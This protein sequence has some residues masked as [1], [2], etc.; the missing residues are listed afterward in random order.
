V[1]FKNTRAISYIDILHNKK[2][3]NNKPTKNY[4]D[5]NNYCKKSDVEYIEFRNTRGNEK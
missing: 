3:P 1:P 2:D 4:P 5:K